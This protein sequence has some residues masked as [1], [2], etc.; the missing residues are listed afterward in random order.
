[1]STFDVKAYEK[2]QEA[3]QHLLIIE[4]MKQGGWR[5]DQNMIKMEVMPGVDTVCGEE[6]LKE[7]SAVLAKEM[8]K[9]NRKILRE[10][11]KTEKAALENI[12]IIPGYKEKVFERYPS[13][14]P[15]YVAT[16]VPIKDK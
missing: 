14:N 11:K 1:M 9:L 15:D 16:D 6:F 12:E 3:N 8:K 10:V 2:F 7:V 5:A 4:S 13:L